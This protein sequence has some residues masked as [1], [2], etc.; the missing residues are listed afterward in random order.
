MSHKKAKIET[1]GDVFYLHTG[2]KISQYSTLWSACRGAV[3]FHYKWITE[4][5]FK[6]HGRVVRITLPSGLMRQ[7]RIVRAPGED[8]VTLDPIKGKRK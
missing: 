5:P 4:K 6:N 3:R 2:G 1:D 7:G 8:V